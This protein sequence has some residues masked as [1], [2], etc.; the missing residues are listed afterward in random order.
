MSNCKFIRKKNRRLC[1]GDLIDWIIIHNRQIKAPDFD[2]ID[3]DE[4]F[5]P[6][7]PESPGRWSMINTIHGK[8]WFDGVSTEERVTHEIGIEFDPGVTSENWVEF[9]GQRLDIL[10]IN[11]LDERKEFMLLICTN[12]GLITKEATKS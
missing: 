9:E 8:T 1:I 5:T 11:P 4:D 10:E 12:R 3:F 6:V 2:A 7:V